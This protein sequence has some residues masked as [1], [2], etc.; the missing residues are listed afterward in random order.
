V[1]QLGTCLKLMKDI[2]SARVSA[3]GVASIVQTGHV[4]PDA[5]SPDWNASG[6]NADEEGTL[7]YF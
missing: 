5:D 1:A 4:W 2:T 7:H 3:C 6:V